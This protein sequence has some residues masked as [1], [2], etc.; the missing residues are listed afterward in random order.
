MVSPDVT[1]AYKIRLNEKFV[2]AMAKCK[3]S[4]FNLTTSVTSFLISG[5]PKLKKVFCRS[6]E[7]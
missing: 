2:K 4:S 7:L 5:K 3:S 1:S 6:V